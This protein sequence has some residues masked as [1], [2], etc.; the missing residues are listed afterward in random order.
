[1]NRVCVDV[2]GMGSFFWFKIPGGPI[3][4]DW[5][6]PPRNRTNERKARTSAKD[7]VMGFHAA[8]ATDD[9]TGER[10][11]LADRFECIGPFEQFSRPEDYLA[12]LQKLHPI[13]ERVEMHRMF[14]EGDDVGMFYDL[15]P[16]TPALTAF[17][18]E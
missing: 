8:M 11:H 17:I 12:S 18:A 2:P 6:M 1:V 14:A 3:L 16:S 4:A 13:V 9:R 15:V 5:Q 7:G 10:R